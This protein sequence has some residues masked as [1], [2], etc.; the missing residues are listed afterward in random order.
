M[1]FCEEVQPSNIMKVVVP[2]SDCAT[3]F[4][5][6][7]EEVSRR[8]LVLYSSDPGDKG[9]VLYALCPSCF[10]EKA[11]ERIGHHS[12]VVKVP[13]LRRSFE[14]NCYFVPK[15]RNNEALELESSV[16]A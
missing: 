7:E 15:W 1:F 11:E 6:I 4:K 5:G 12:P 9:E 16:A 14:P 3:E 8:A 2:C 10:K 13:G